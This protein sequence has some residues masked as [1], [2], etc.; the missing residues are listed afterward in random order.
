MSNNN[1][2]ALKKGDPDY[3]TVLGNIELNSGIHYWEIKV[4]IQKDLKICRWGGS[5]PRCG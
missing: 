3:Q 1:L 2:T 4:S 5:F